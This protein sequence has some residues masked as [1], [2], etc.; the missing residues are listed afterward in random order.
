MPIDS[1]IRQRLQK[2]AFIPRNNINKRMADRAILFPN[3]GSEPDITTN[4]LLFQWILKRLCTVH[5]ICP[6]W[7]SFNPQFTRKVMTTHLFSNPISSKHCLV[8]STALCGEQR[9]TGHGYFMS[10]VFREQISV[11]RG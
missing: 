7:I 3:Q 9:N 5:F 10:A 6:T 11:K 4:P 8:P 1:Q 2:I